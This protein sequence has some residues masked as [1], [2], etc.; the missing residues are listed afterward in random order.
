M[1]INLARKA[2]EAASWPTSVETGRYMFPL[3]E[4]TRNVADVRAEEARDSFL[5]KQ[6]SIIAASNL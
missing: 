1:L 2:F 6:R 4:N 5:K 3:G